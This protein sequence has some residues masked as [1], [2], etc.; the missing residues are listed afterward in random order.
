MADFYAA[1]RTFLRCSEEASRRCRLT[2][3][4]FLLLLMIKGAPDRSERLSF[5]EVAER[6][7]LSRNSVTGLVARGEQAGLIRRE[8]SATDRRVIHLRLT[9]EGERR[10]LEALA[11]SDQDLRRFAKALSEIAAPSPGSTR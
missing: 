9:P 2:P 10:L 8:R 7:K 5:R 6:L 3:Q 1:L 4:R 11:A